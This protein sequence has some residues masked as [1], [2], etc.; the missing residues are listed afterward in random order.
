MNV[1]S[2]WHTCMIQEWHGRCCTRYDGKRGETVPESHGSCFSSSDLWETR[3]PKTREHVQPSG[4]ML[5]A[6]QG[7][8]CNLIQGQM[9]QLV[10]LVGS[11]GPA[12][13]RILVTW[14]GHEAGP[15]RKQW[16]VRKKESVGSSTG[17]R[18]VCRPARGH[19]SMCMQ[20]GGMD[21]RRRQFHN[22]SASVLPFTRHCWMGA[23]LLVL[24]C[25]EWRKR[26]EA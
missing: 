14:S 10:G 13:Y 2:R 1:R 25:I 5:G 11:Q 17:H 23:G 15:G 9:S 18:R 24:G 26:G 3:S 7:D 16:H 21:R 6:V 8:G 20:R 4:C 12:S 22:F 19:G